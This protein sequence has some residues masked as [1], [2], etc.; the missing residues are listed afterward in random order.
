MWRKSLELT[1]LQRKLKCI[2]AHNKENK[3]T[4]Q[5]IFSQ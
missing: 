3:D 5:N 2:N 4:R 1:K